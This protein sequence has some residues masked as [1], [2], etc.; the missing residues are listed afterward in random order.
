MSIVSRS[1][2]LPLTNHDDL[3]LAF[4]ISDGALDLVDVLNDLRDSGFGEEGA[5]V[6]YCWLC[7]AVCGWVFCLWEVM[8]FEWKMLVALVP[9]RQRWSQN[10]Y[11]LLANTGSLGK[12]GYISTMNR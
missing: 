1:D 6:H 8:C 2:A 11:L 5:F 10:S 9:E 3:T 7:L 4:G 12:G